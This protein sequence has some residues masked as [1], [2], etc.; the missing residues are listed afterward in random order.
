MQ[1]LLG[2]KYIYTATK[3]RSQDD[4]TRMEEVRSCDFMCLTKDFL[5]PEKKLLDVCSKQV[6]MVVGGR[7]DNG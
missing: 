1:G 4:A 3:R 7:M 5:V 6:A 2:L